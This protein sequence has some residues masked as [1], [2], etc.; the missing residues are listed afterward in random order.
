MPRACFPGP[1]AHV[2]SVPEPIRLVVATRTAATGG[3]ADAIVRLTFAAGAA[4]P[5]DSRVDIEIQGEQHVDAVLVPTEAIIRSGNQTAVLV[6]AGD[7]AERRMVTTGLSDADS[8]E[9]VAGVE[10]GGLATTRW[11]SPGSA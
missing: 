6:A 8:V 9:I 1:A 4:M 5:V 10:A 2:T 3:G 11:H 7:R